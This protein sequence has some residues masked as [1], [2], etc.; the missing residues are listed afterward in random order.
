MVRSIGIPQLILI[1]TILFVRPV[2]STVPSAES[3]GEP[4][5][6]AGGDC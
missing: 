1:I 2:V 6:L 4:G 3:R 5:T